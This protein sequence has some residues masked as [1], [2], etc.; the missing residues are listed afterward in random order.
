LEAEKDKK[1]QIVEAYIKSVAEN[2]RLPTRADLVNQGISKD[3]VR[4]HFNNLESLHDYIHENHLEEVEKYV[5]TDKTVFSKVRIQ[6]L[7]E[8]LKNYKRFVVTTV[9]TGKELNKDFYA[10]L[11]NYCSRMDACLLLI[12]CADIASTRSSWTWTFP[13]ELQ[14]ANF[15]TEDVELNENIFIS[16]IRLSAKQIKPTT[17]LNR[18]GQRNG[19]YI[20]AS[21]KQF[22]EYVVTS[23]ETGRLPHAIMTPGA[24]TVADYE[25]DLYMSERTAYI[26]QNDHVYGAVIVEIQDE[27]IFHFRQVQCDADGVVIDLGIEYWPNG[28]ITYINSSIVLGDW[29]S[30]YT[31]PVVKDLLVDIVDTVGCS[32]AF[33]HDF[34]DGTSISHHDLNFPL[35][36]AK[37]AMENKSSLENEL[38]TG[39]YD[40]LW[41]LG[42]FERLVMVKGNHDEFLSRYLIKGTYVQDPQNHYISLT[43]AKEL[44]DGNDPLKYG[45]EQ[46]G[47]LTEEELKRIKWLRRDEEYKIAGIELGQHGDLGLNGSKGSLMSMERSFGDCVVGHAHSAAI[48]RGVWR[49]G[50]STNLR[51]D[52]TVGPTSWCQT[53]CIVYPNGS[54]QLIN[55][56]KGKWRLE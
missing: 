47:V 33:I 15:I 7:R 39:A 43:L 9:V 36:L 53:H 25:T 6:Q 41:L 34:F 14:D 55:I 21:P 50:T 20:F 44:L 24:L 32:T 22:L 38:E 2:K 35:K 48:L 29:H 37:K 17:G 45:Y 40:L 13:P 4:H 16:S 12:P 46:T 1:E 3:T 30:G 56:I 19:S 5:L 31:D 26:A 10:S 18:I 23:P 11:Q 8:D 49:V 42:L 27:Q 52:Y 54:R 28:E 51:L